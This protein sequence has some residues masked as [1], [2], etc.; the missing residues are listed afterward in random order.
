MSTYPELQN[1]V[2]VV[3]GAGQGLGLALAEAFALEGCRVVGVVRRETEWPATLQ[4]PQF[5]EVR[6][7]IR[8]PEPL[9][10]WLDAWEAA[11]K[12]V[13][14]LVNNAGTMMRG[15]LIDADLAGYEQMFDV[16][17]RALFRMSQRFA[18]HM[19][20]RNGGSIINM[21]SYAATLASVSHGLYAASKAAA[22]S[23]TRSMAAEWAPYGIRVNAISPGVVPTDMTRP[24]LEKNADRMCDMISL[25]R[26]G[27]PAEVARVA[28]FLASDAASYLTGINLE[29]TGGKLIV[30][31]PAAA[32]RNVGHP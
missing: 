10:A 32:W 28:T 22:W 1:R 8:A 30:Q 11:G 29:A 12:K 9:F 13:D 17:T 4:G 6:C 16:N 5:S 24:A 27:S 2:A 31:D 26:V 20:S 14:I 7:D 21:T 3:T 25:R 15:D 18:Q 19:R 23:L